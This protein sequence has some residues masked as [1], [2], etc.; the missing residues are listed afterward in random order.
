MMKRFECKWFIIKF[1]FFAG[2]LSILIGCQNSNVLTIQ[3]EIDSITIRLVPD[4]RIGICWITAKP[5]AKGSIILGGETTSSDV[6]LEIIKT[7]NNQGIKLIDSIIIL[8]DTIMNEKFMGLAT[9]SVI[10]LRKQPDHRSELVSQAILGTP[11]LILKDEDSW[12]LIQTPDLYIAWTEK[13]SVKMMNRLE[14]NAW[15]KA[16]KV[17]YLENTGWIYNSPG[18][19]G[20]V[21]DL[22]AGSIM[23]KCGE[24][25]SYINV[26]LPDGRKGFVNKPAVIK[27]DIFRNSGLPDEESVIRRASSLLGVPYLW[28]GSS[29]KGI[30]CSGFVQS[31]FFMN[32]L[33]LMRDASLQALHGDKVDISN[34]FSQ[35]KKGDLLFFGSKENSKSHVTH[36]AIYKG[37]NEYINSSG[38]VIINSLDS[39]DTNF[40]KYRL[41]SL[42][43]ARRIIGVK[44]APGIV[45]VNKH[46]WY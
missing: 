15:K 25:G 13:S 11:L 34:G 35:L 46:L 44:N 32:G 12:L 33:I 14:M 36:V 20:V 41:H 9:L 7:L 26:L 2:F 37:D 39:A 43:A 5:G 3:S 45:P 40:S 6:K 21:G 18:G 38:R 29:S 42:L 27:F 8:P 23:E 10:N 24:S 22:V 17:I 16:E 1:V 4:Q 31:V 30:D 28:G 19:P